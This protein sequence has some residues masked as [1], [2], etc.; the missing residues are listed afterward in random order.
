MAIRK[1]INKDERN[2][3]NRSP[4]NK[5]E[6]NSICIPRKIYVFRTKWYGKGRFAHKTVTSS[7]YKRLAHIILQKLSLFLSSQKKVTRL[8]PSSIISLSLLLSLTHSLSLWLSNLHYFCNIG[9]W[10]T[11]QRLQ[12]WRPTKRA[13]TQKCFHIFPLPPSL[14]PSCLLAW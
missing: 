8:N 9:H 7:L 2:V 4:A 3:G 6:T 14:P 13:S 11:T 10:H 1:R 5:V 12:I